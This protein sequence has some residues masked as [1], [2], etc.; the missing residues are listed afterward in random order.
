MHACVPSCL[1]DWVVTMPLGIHAGPEN[2]NLN[3]SPQL[4][5]V[6]PT[7]H[8]Q[9]D[10]VAPYKLMNEQLYVSDTY[11]NTVCSSAQA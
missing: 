10:H 5:R 6:V 11:T 4:K 2:L 8:P 1:L 9:L 3:C 7:L